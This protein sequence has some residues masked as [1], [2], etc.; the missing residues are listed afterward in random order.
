MSASHTHSQ[1]VSA[2]SPEYALL[3]F[4][5]QGPAHG[6][7]L[8]RRLS[9]SLDQV[10]H[11][12]LSQTYNILTRLEGSGYIIGKI[13]AQPKL[14][15][16]KEFHLTA[17]GRRRFNTWLRTP[18][19]CSVRAIRVEFTTR[20]YFAHASDHALVRNLIDTQTAE[21]EQGLQHLRELLETLP[22]EQTF[23]RLGLMLRIRQLASL[24]EWLSECRQALGLSD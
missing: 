9:E 16:R 11:V 8:H 2:L 4:L 7:E 6:Y 13:Q 18:T 22:Q 20:L 5:A 14:P 24:I 19:G 17:A 1:Y 3:G 21:V 12:S 15:P 23:N 10:W